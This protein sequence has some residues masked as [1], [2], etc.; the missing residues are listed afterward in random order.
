MLDRFGLKIITKTEISKH[1]KEGVM[2]GGVAHVIQIIVF[3]TGAHAA[4]RGHGSLVGALVLAEKHILELDHS[5]IGEKQRGIVMRYQWAAGNHLV[6]VS[7]EVIEKLLSDIASFHDNDLTNNAQL[8][9]C[10]HTSAM[11]ILTA[12]LP[13]AEYPAYRALAEPPSL[14]ISGAACPVFKRVN[15]L[16]GEATLVAALGHIIP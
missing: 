6:A 3:A 7:G 9:A 1:L 13:I 12:T 10:I 4:L 5:R 16:V 15:R 11:S 8:P 2:P 14:H